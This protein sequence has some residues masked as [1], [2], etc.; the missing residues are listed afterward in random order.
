VGRSARNREG[1]KLRQQGHRGAGSGRGKQKHE[2]LGE[3][4]SKEKRGDVGWDRKRAFW[5]Q[6][7][8]GTNVKGKSVERRKISTQTESA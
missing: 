4:K 5:G 6:T 8:R 3:R 2:Y 7:N 1:I